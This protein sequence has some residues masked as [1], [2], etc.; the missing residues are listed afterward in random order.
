MTDDL[1]SMTPVLQEESMV[2]EIMAMF[3]AHTDH[4]DNQIRQACLCVP[5]S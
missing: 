3:A 1:V 4:K 2:P 5:K